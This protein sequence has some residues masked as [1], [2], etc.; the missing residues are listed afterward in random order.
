MRGIVVLMAAAIGSFGP[1]HVAFAQDRPRPVVEAVVGTSGYVDEVWDH[2]FTAGAG[3]RWF[4][5]PRLAVGPE[6]VTQRGGHEASNL[7]VTGN[8]T[9]DL[10]QDRPGR[11][12]V[13]YIAAGGGYLR[14]RTIVGSGPGST[15]L[16]PFTSGEGTFSGGIGARI[17]LGERVFV[18]PEFR[19]GWEPE[20]RFVAMIGFR[21][22]R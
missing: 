5:T 4:V 19:L 13:P 9:Y 11:R 17:A 20:M 2:F 16:Q 21:P 15:V 8:V 6:I 12:V 3:A 1:V 18:A 7:S 10:L 14:Q 22:G